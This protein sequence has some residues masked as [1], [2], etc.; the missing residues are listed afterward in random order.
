MS[1]M[2]C[3]VCNYPIAEGFNFCVR[4]GAKLDQVQPN[5]SEHTD[6]TQF[7]ES[8]PDQIYPPH[9]GYIPTEYSGQPHPYPEPQKKDGKALKAIVIAMILLAVSVSGIFYIM[10]FDCGSFEPDEYVIYGSGAVYSGVIKVESD[11]EDLDPYDGEASVILTSCPDSVSGYQWRV[12]PVDYL[13]YGNGSSVS[14]SIISTS[15]SGKTLSCAL[16]PGLYKVDLKVNGRTHTGT[17]ALEGEVSREYSWDYYQIVDGVGNTY[18]PSIKHEFQTEFSFLYGECVTSLDYDGRRGY[19][20][21]KDAEE[22]MNVFVSDSKTIT[23]RLESM[24]REAFDDKG[25]PYDFKDSEGFHYASYLLAFVQQ[26]I[27]YE[28]DS[29]LYWTEEYWAFPA[30]TIMR[31]QGDCEDT[32]FL[33]AA[34]FKAA[35][36][37]TVTGLL[38]GHAMAGISLSGGVV[39]DRTNSYTE[40]LPNNYLIYEDIGGKRFYAC[41][42]TYS[43]QFVIGYTNITHT[44]VGEDGETKEGGLNKWLPGN[45]YASETKTYG[46][47]EVA[48]F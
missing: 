3:P 5:G 19:I 26:A 43:S 16:E 48:A 46:F 11:P 22:I 25:I 36:F 2:R 13:R 44:E 9:S 4:C 40:V 20:L 1:D 6:K 27:K 35:G 17:F 39:E 47:Y 38:P 21:F 30:E 41:E 24:L 28:S 15:S 34:L 12:T 33:C 37:D 7:Q 23:V 18:K 10:P 42:T 31:G 8:A 14:P 45:E 32:S 29:N